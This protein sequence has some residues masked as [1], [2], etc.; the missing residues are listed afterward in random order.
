MDHIYYT[1]IADN[2]WSIP[3]VQDLSKSKASRLR[4]KIRDIKKGNV[5]DDDILKP[6]P[7][8]RP[9]SSS[10]AY[11]PPTPPGA[12]LRTSYDPRE[13]VEVTT[14]SGLVLPPTAIAYGHIPL[15]QFKGNTV[16]RVDVGIPLT[17]TIQHLPRARTVPML[18]VAKEQ[19]EMAATPVSVP[20][21]VGV[22]HLCLSLCVC[23]SV[24]VK[25]YGGFCG[26]EGLGSG[27]ESVSVR[28]ELYYCHK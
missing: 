1:V 9:S 2:N 26:C 3:N 24:S 5:V 22:C 28:M 6:L 8:R 10:V 25:I 7:R 21:S 15:A 18:K 23:H 11:K 19:L 17:Y 4:T 14:E 12:K 27:S 16:Q 13:K 20:M